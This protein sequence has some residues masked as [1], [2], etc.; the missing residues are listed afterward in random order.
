MQPLF[1]LLLNVAAIDI[2]LHVDARTAT[3]G[4][5]TAAVVA[6]A[7]V[8][9]V[10]VKCTCHYCRFDPLMLLLLLPPFMFVLL[11]LWLKQW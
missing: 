7:G 2:T 10:D 9:A 3:A 5:A 8:A 6:V 11:T 1:L 4:S